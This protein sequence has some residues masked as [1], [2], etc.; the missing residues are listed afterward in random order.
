MQ[1]E[2]RLTPRFPILAPA[3]VTDEQSAIVV[4]GL[5]TELSEYGC[6]V[7]TGMPFPRGTH[8]RLNTVHKGQ[9]LAAQGRVAYLAIGAMGIVFSRVEADQQAILCTWL[10]ACAEPSAHAS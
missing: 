7:R 10:A 5:L 8:V 4:D 1:P 6:M 3:Q 9:A 2:R